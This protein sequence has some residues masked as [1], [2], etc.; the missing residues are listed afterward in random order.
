M[1]A[2]ESLTGES[3]LMSTREYMQQTKLNEMNIGNPL[4]IEPHLQNVKIHT[5]EQH[6]EYNEWRKVFSNYSLKTR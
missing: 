6:F 4:L 5:G 2:E 3:L 1:N